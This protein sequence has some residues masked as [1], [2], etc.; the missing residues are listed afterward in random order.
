MK[1]GNETD[2]PGFQTDGHHSGG[3]LSLKQ[4]LTS[5]WKHHVWIVII[6]I[7]NTK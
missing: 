2:D 6:F 7:I 4:M 1:F 3:N 5:N